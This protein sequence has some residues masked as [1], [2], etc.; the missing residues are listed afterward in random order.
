VTSMPPTLTTDDLNYL[1]SQHLGRLATVDPSGA[2]QNSPVG[3]T[4]DETTGQILIGGMAMSDSRKFRNVLHN[5][6]LALVVDDLASV[7]PWIVRGI[8]VRGEAEALV[9][10]DPP[11]AMMSREVIRITP[12]WIYSWGISSGDDRRKRSA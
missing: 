7:D 12:R 11:M 9:D 1:Q 4:V 5:P 6:N 8:E 2:P 3:F 10:V